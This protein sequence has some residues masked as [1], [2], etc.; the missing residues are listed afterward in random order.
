[1]RLR[2]VF[3]FVMLAMLAYNLATVPMFRAEFLT[4]SSSIALVSVVCAFILPA[5]YAWPFQ[6][7]PIG[8]VLWHVFTRPKYQPAYNYNPLDIPMFLVLGTFLLV[9]AFPTIKGTLTTKP[10]KK[11]RHK[12]G[13]PRDPLLS[14]WPI[15]K[16]HSE[17]A[18][19]DHT[20]HH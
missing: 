3:G 18:A 8:W 9:L 16:K 12:Q 13:K 5:K 1:M 7:G 10:A 20:P 2:I 11:V 17:P 4:T 14:Q 6:A 19:H 15:G